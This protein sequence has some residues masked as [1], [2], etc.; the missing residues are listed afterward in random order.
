MAG[1]QSE[2]QNER[3]FE[4]VIEAL[5]E[6]GAGIANYERHTII[7]PKTLPGETVQVEYDPARP[8]KERIQLLDIVSPEAKRIDAPCRWYDKCGG[9]HLQ[10]TNYEDQLAYKRQ[11]IKNALAAYPQF[12]N[13]ELEGPHP[14]P[15]PSHYRNKTQLPFQQ[16]NGKAAFGLYQM[17]SHQLIPIDQCLVENQDAN[18]VSTIVRD[19][20]N[21]H[22]I[23]IYDEA[24]GSGLLRY[25]MIRK[26]IFS[27]EVMVVLVVTETAIPNWQPLLEALKAGVPRLKSFQFNINPG[28]TNIV[29]GNE[30]IL[31]WGDPWITEKLGKYCYRIYPQTFF[32]VNSV[33]TVKLLR[34]LIEDAGLQSQDHII[35]LFCGVGAISLQVAEHVRKVTGI[36]INPESIR[37]AN[38]TA[39]DNNISNV[40]YISG[41]VLDGFKGTFEGEVVDGIIVDPPR[42]GLSEPLIREMTALAPRFIAYISCNP[43]TL[44][45]DLAHFAADGYRPDR[46]SLYDMFPQTYHVECLTVLRK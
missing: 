39:V 18:R 26:G 3:R 35:D 14:M 22:G 5:N 43:Q 15:E 23:S 44:L 29:L 9:C 42:K 45:R 37:A 13:I 2:K 25:V 46:I 34:E 4:V 30:N 1:K 36:E 38:E 7:I 27:G 21:R 12:A 10:H 20:A 33:Q 17:G 16:R 6:K 31:A 41:D 24:S 19:W 8:R 28:R 11:M 40:Q 32:Q